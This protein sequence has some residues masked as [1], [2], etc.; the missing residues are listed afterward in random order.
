[1]NN[2]QKR[3]CKETVVSTVECGGEG[4]GSRNKLPAPGNPEKLGP[5]P[6]LAGPDCGGPVEWIELA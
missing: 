5:A 4:G 1:M 2:E 6:P 3:I